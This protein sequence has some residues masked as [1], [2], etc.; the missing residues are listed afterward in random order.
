MRGET[1][2][3]PRTPP[4][5]RRLRG[6]VDDRLTPVDTDSGCHTS[7][8]DL[9]LLPPPSEEELRALAASHQEQKLQQLSE[10]EAI[11]VARDSQREVR[12]VLEAQAQAEA[13]AAEVEAQ[14]EA[15]AEYGRIVGEQEAAAEAARFGMERLLAEQ[16]V[17]EGLARAHMERMVAE[18]EAVEEQRAAEAAKEAA[19]KAEAEAVA[20]QEASK[21]T[22]LAKEAASNAEDC[23][24]A[25]KEAEAVMKLAKEAEAA[26]RAAT[27][28]EAAKKAAREAGIA[29][30]V[31]KK[32]LL[33][34]EKLIL[35]HQP[36]MNLGDYENIVQ[37]LSSTTSLKG[38]YIEVGVFRGNSAVAAMEYIT[39]KEMTHRVCY[40]FDTF[41]GFTYDAVY[42]SQDIR[43]VDT[44]FQET[45]ID[46]VKSRL[47]GYSNCKV[48]K[49]NIIT[50]DLPASINSCA[51]AN[52]DVD[53]Y[54]ATKHALLK[55]VPIMV[56][57]GIIILEDYGHTPA[58]LGGFYAIREFMRSSLMES[59]TRIHMPTGQ[60]F[61]IKHS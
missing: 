5:R 6:V 16:A 48:R 35:D 55:V 30:K 27:E 59:F 43:F 1:R 52:I 57:G 22:K 42:T 28:A 24:K 7:P 8:V 61:L 29:E 53:S 34:A 56:N 31:A 45:S 18:N 20:L 9:D 36:R 11:R 3:V 41:E 15:L 60:L 47:D 19:R 4:P 44:H 58:T 46:Y 14:E 51:V 37:A 17:A 39:K 49:V 25:A 23:E 54:E 2:L 38:V 40:F 50:D 33:S 21:Q 10:D 26:Q 32:A 13:R 12:A